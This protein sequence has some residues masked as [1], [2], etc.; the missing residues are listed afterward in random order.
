[1]KIKNKKGFIA[2]EMI[3][4]IPRILYLTA[5]LFATVILIKVFIIG[6]IDVREIE[7]NILINRL[8]YSKDGLSYYDKDL[9]RIYP[10]IIELRKFNEMSSSNP[11]T[12]DNSIISYGAD[13]PIISA[14]IILRQE[15]KNDIVVYYNK[16]GYDKWEPR[17]LTTVKG[18]AGSPKSIKEQKY[19]LVKEEDK[20]T[21]AILEFN[22]VS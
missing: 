19:V 18:G 3:F 21:P 15:G 20:M 1:M 4:F 10:G 7:S 2:E 16:N 14:K 8:I 11:N 12:L 9:N 6:A 13:N 17:I 22:V 5:V